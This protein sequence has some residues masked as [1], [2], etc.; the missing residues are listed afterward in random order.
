MGRVFIGLGS[1]QGDRLT[2][3]SGAVRAL[4]TLE[5]VRVVQ[6]AMIVETEPVGPPQGPYLNTVV[7]LDTA[8]APEELLRALQDIER[9]LGRVPSPQRWG[10]RVIDLDLLLYDDQV[11]QRPGLSVPHPR[12][13]ERGF[14]LEPL[15]QLAPDAVH[16]ILQQSVA[17][18]RE[19]L[20]SQRSRPSSPHPIELAPR[21]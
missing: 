2:A 20:A 13:H 11:I 21:S 18:L 16:P 9:Q 15:A 4:S 6:M 7:E 1:N 14:V 19:Q 12:M 8:R 5:G 17:A 10:P 3:I